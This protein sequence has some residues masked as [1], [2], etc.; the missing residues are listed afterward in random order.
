MNPL[1][2][3]PRPRSARPARSAR[4]ARVAGLCS[5]LLGALLAAPGL[6][7]CNAQIYP[8]KMLGPKD[9]PPGDTKR[10]LAGPEEVTVVRHADPIR[11]RTPGATAGY[12][13]HFYD[14][15]QRIQAGTG[16]IASSGGK[17]EVV[18]PLGTSVVM[19]GPATGVVGST[20]RGEATFIFEE[21]GRAMLEL[22]E[23][24]VIR[25]VGGAILTGPSGPYLLELVKPEVIRVTNQSKL[26]LNVTYRTGEFEIGPGQRIDLPLVASGGA[27]LPG[28][29]GFSNVA[30]PGFGVAVR[31]AVQA[32]VLPNGVA[33]Q[34]DG[35]NEVQGLGVRVELPEGQQ[36]VFSGL[37]GA[38]A[39][40]PILEP[41]SIEPSGPEPET[42]AESPDP[43]EGV[44]L[45]WPTTADSRTARAS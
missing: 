25:L 35:Q 43:S 38:P 17:A 34:A 27:P 14:K 10:W 26:P 33:L 16:V 42:Q 24:D 28:L 13:M 4:S 45:R 15:V 29:E 37:E 18:W 11:I 19:F 3:A 8:G 9:L 22:L 21:L 23:G 5:L 30:G 44:S 40:E 6:V 20:S 2:A 41:P 31:G 39:P 36:A 12:P 32:A 1:Q 7:G